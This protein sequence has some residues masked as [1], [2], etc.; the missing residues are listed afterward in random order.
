ME[1]YELFK[2]LDSNHLKAKP[3]V[4]HVDNLINQSAKSEGVWT[5]SDKSE[6]IRGPHFFSTP[7]RAQT[8]F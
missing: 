8:Q 5:I 1:V 4:R 3:I 6:G 2:K 7:C